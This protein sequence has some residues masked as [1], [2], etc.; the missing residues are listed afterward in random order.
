MIFLYD[1][2]HILHF[3]VMLRMLQ[4][5]LALCHSVIHM[6]S[7]GWYRTFDAEVIDTFLESFP[8]FLV[9]YVYC[10]LPQMMTLGLVK[11]SS[12]PRVVLVRSPSLDRMT[13]RPLSSFW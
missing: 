4:A 11:I 9:W 5:V 10:Y 6:V 3:Q 7:I 1:I 13:L 8:F 12:F 2:C